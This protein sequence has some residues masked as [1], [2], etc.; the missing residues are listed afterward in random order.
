[1][2]GALTRRAALGVVGTALVPLAGCSDL[3]PSRTPPHGSVAVENDADRAHMVAVTV[4]DAA[5]EVLLDRTFSVDPGD[6]EATDPVV[7]QRG[8]YHV[9]AEVDDV[10]R[11]ERIEFEREGP[12]GE[13]IYGYVLV[14]VD[15]PPTDVSVGGPPMGTGSP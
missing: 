5:D 4:T 11:E 15:G 10:T 13:E 7:A 3:R 9:R 14:Y 8:T 12:E 1:M 6:V 2:R